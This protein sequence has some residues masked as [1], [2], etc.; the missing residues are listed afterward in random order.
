M[1]NG[2]WSKQWSQQVQHWF[3]SPRHDRVTLPKTP[4]L[5]RDPLL[6][7]VTQADTTAQVWAFLLQWLAHEALGSL[8]LTTVQGY[9]LTLRYSWPQV[10]APV[11]LDTQRNQGHHLEQ[12]AETGDT[13]YCH[14]LSGLGDYLGQLLPQDAP[15]QYFSVPLRVGNTT[16]AIITLG[17]R[18]ITPDSQRLVSRVYEQKE[19]LGQ[20]LANCVLKEA[21]PGGDEMASPQRE[22]QSICHSLTA[23]IAAKDPY[24]AGHSYAVAEYAQKLAQW[25]GLSEADTWPIRLAG[26]LHD[27]GKIGI[28]DHILRKPG[29]LT[30]EEWTVMHT[31]PTIGAEQILAPLHAMRAVVPLVLHHHEHWD[32]SGYPYGLSGDGIPLGARLVSLVDAYHGLTSTRTYRGAMSRAETLVQMQQDAGTLWDPDL[33]HAFT[34]LVQ[35]QPG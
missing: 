8:W 6:N 16:Q 10:A 15:T 9:T 32:G 31:H 17:F 34:L 12:C 7:F 21:Q 2:L 35:T 33:L 11:Q 18:Q 30:P 4:K 26:Q 24:T 20:L 22:A 27:V 1:P 29:P 14:G 13:T 19:L 25:I 28:P 23:A 3:G 5:S